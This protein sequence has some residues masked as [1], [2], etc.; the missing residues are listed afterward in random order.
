M[1]LLGVSEIKFADGDGL[2]MKEAGEGIYE[3]LNRK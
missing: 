3:E 2:D 1:L